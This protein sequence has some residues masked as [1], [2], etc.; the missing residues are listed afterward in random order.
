PRLMAG[1]TLVAMMGVEDRNDDGPGA[2]P[3][4]PCRL[5]PPEPPAHHVRRGR[6]HGLLEDEVVAP[7][8][9]VGAPAGAGKTSL[10]AGWG[11]GAGRGAGLG[12]DEGARDAVH[13]WRGVL[14]AVDALSPGAGERAG[15][16]LQ[17][18]AT[19]GGAVARLIDDLG[20]REAP[21]SVL[22]LD[23]A[24]LVDADAL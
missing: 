17:G 13:L 15:A 24:H 21:R 8:T 5:R 2:G 11:G 22:V 6:L 23:D 1:R 16:A 12:L 10:L 4:V 19:V 9:L 7:L 18:P 3:I 20:D 14:A